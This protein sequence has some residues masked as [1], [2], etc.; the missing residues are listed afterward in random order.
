MQTPGRW[1][2]TIKLGSLMFFSGWQDTNL[3]MGIF[4]RTVL[5]RANIKQNTKSVYS[6]FPF[7]HQFTKLLISSLTEVGYL[8]RR[9]F[10]CFCQD[11]S[12]ASKIFWSSFASYTLA[13]AVTAVTRCEDSLYKQSCSHFLLY[14]SGPY[15]WAGPDG[16]DD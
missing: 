12:I 11:A 3:P 15:S 16:Q 6:I 7:C 13:M 4:C 1:F 2:E 14:C 8:P 9:I 5:C 10:Q